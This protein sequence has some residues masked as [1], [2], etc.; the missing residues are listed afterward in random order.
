MSA[1][2]LKAAIRLEWVSMTASDPK[3]KLVLGVSNG[4]RLISKVTAATAIFCFLLVTL[5]GA[6]DPEPTLPICDIA[7]LQDFDPQEVGSNAGAAT[8][9]HDVYYISL[10]HGRICTDADLGW[11]FA[12]LNVPS[13]TPHEKIGD[14]ILVPDET[15]DGWAEEVWLGSGDLGPTSDGEPPLME[16]C[17]N[18]GQSNGSEHTDGNVIGSIKGIFDYHVR[19][20]IQ[21]HTLV[22]SIKSPTGYSPTLDYGCVVRYIDENDFVYYDLWRFRIEPVAYDSNEDALIWGIGDFTRTNIYSNDLSA[23]GNPDAERSP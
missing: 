1:F 22:E 13:S 4:K 6:D 9:S 19:T 16:V 10:K 7:L 2:H 12:Y 8:V 15:G 21:N 11:P 5:A 14:V 18:L 23:I 20:Y 17:L 3:R